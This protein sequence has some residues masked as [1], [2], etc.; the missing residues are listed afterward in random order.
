MWRDDHILDL[1]R[2]K[3]YHAQAFAHRTKQRAISFHGSRCVEPGVE[4]EA[5]FPA[6]NRPDK[7]VERHGP[8][9]RIAADEIVRSGPVV[10]AVADREQIVSLAQIGYLPPKGKLPLQGELRIILLYCSVAAWRCKE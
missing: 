1:V 5:A 2:I 4:D 3:P 7:V 10:M 6:H 9:V 8:I